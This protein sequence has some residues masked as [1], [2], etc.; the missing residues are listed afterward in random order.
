[1]GLILTSCS[2]VEKLDITIKEYDIVVGVENKQETTLHIQKELQVRH[3][4]GRISRG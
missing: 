4:H 1:M 3:G 2:A